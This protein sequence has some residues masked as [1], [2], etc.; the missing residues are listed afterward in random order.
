[1]VIYSVY[2]YFILIKNIKSVKV[3]KKIINKSVKI[4]KILIAIC[5]AIKYLHTIK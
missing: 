4:I 5:N 2:I 3:S 1:M